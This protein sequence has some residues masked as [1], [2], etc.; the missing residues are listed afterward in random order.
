MTID[1]ELSERPESQSSGV[2]RVWARNGGVEAERQDLGSIRSRAGVAGKD[3]VLSTT[4][5]AK[6]F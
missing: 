4:K 3:D 2:R 1:F 6:A 5:P